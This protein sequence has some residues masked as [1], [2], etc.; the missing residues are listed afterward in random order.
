MLNEDYKDMLQSLSA[1]EV[2]FL[3]VGAYA[4]AA[5]GYPRATGDFDIWVEASP[6]NSKKI[7]SSLISF[8]SPTS[9]LTE[10]TFM[11]KGIIF[12]IGVAPRRIDLITHIDGVDFNNAYPSRTT[13]VMEGL[14]LPFIS[15]ENLIKNKKSTGRDKDLVDVKHLEE[16]GDA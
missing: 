11:Q 9:E 7:L 6:E 16:N 2:K 5:Y 4:L 3:I 1:H 10:I 15:K 13:I 14:N 12:Q 8:G